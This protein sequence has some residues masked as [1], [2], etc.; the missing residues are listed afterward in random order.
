MLETFETVAKAVADPSRVR[1]LKLLENGELCVCQITTVLDLAP[2]TVSKHLA[3]LKTAGLLQQ[4][5]DGKWVYYRLAER[6][7]N[8]YARSFLDLVGASMKDDPTTAE[9]RRVL[10][11]VNAVP[12][13]VLCDQGRAA[14]FSNAQAQSTCCGG[15]P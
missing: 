10:A 1:I 14:L 3:A 6:D 8:A 11:L 13:Q 9:D 5:R 15:P 2:A 7:F 4:R 12:V